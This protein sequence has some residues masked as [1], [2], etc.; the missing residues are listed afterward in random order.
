MIRPRWRRGGAAVAAQVRTDDGVPGRDQQRRDGMPG[1][2]RAGMPVQQYHWRAV[3][4]DA[5]PQPHVVVV[6]I[7]PAQRETLKHVPILPREPSA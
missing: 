2:M 1:G 5:D 4:P 6:D 3:T 7:D